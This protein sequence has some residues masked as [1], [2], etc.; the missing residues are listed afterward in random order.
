MSDRMK[1]NKGNKYNVNDQYAEEVIAK[2]GK[3]PAQNDPRDGVH[4]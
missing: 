1:E 3:H 2:N 4:K